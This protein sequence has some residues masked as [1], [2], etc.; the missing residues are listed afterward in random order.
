M[1]KIHTSAILVDSEII[2][3]T[4]KN[5]FSLTSSPPK[6]QKD[7]DPGLVLIIS[8]TEFDTLSNLPLGQERIGYLN[9]SSFISGIVSHFWVLYNEKKEI[10]MIPYESYR[11]L[12]DLMK[13]FFT[14]VSADTIIWTSVPLKSTDFSSGTEIFSKNKFGNPYVTS[15]TP[16]YTDI[17]PSVALSRKNMNDSKEESVSV[18]NEIIQ[19]IEQYKQSGNIC[20][21]FAQISTRGVGFLKQASRQGITIG[22]DGK[23]SQKELTGELYVKD[24]VKEEGKII[25]VIDID[26]SSVESGEEENVDV[27]ATRA[28]F[29]SHPHEAYVRH[30]VDKAWPSQTDYLGYHKLGANTIF[31]CVAT[32]EGLYILS[33]GSYWG[34]HLDKVNR[35]F[36]EKHFDVD[37]KEPYTPKEYCKK[38]NSI[39][40]KGYP[41]YE[42]LFF[43]WDKAGTVFKIYF[44]TTEG[45]CIASQKSMDNYRKLY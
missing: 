11:Y 38:I 16:L 37:H 41:I 32:L 33:F 2:P 31:H 21:L 19:V 22:K 45:S 39:L 7:F 44:P 29:H 8:T 9:S 3:D 36:I 27:R 23:K 28:N 20:S 26:K 25:Y 24:V 40:Y 34:Q 6:A 10:C 30:S 17:E 13:A 14:G 43:T 5:L 15:L 12:S 42:V 35:S 4:H 1:S 18:L